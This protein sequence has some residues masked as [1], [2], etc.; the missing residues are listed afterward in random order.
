MSLKNTEILDDNSEFQLSQKRYKERLILLVM[1]TSIYLFL[2][3]YF[4]PYL[5]DHLFQ[6]GDIEV[7]FS[8]ISFL[9][10]LL[11][12]SLLLPQY[13]D[14]L[15]PEWAILS[16]A[17]GSGVLFFAAILIKVFTY[18]FFVHHIGIHMNYGYIFYTSS[19]LGLLAAFASNVR[20]MK[21]RG[22]KT[23]LAWIALFV[24]WY[25]LTAIAKM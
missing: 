12:N 21:L 3:E 5:P 6:I 7:R 11:I 18:N 13:L 23:Y 8:S 1:F 15:N 16:I 9:F 2:M 10:I 24:A 17:I 25:I 19:L 4:R 14:K 20:I 22:R